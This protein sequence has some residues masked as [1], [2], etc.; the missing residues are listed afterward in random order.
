[1]DAVLGRTTKPM[2]SPPALVLG[3]AAAVAVT[4]Y[5]IGSKPIL[6]GTPRPAPPPA[7]CLISGSSGFRPLSKVDSLENC[8]VQLEGVYLA[9]G[10][11][12][13]GGYNGM[14]LF[15]DERGIDVAQSDGPRQT[16]IAPWMRQQVDDELHRLMRKRD[17]QSG[18]MQITVVRP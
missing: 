6:G 3:V 4:F 2:T 16:L 18:G 7:D 5:M 9:D 13:T 12:V 14:R 15:V 17:G 8:G 1:M 10:E 11:P